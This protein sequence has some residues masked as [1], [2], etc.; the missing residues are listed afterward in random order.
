MNAINKLMHGKMHALGVPPI[1]E[2]L[3]MLVDYGAKLLV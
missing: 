3:Q 1:G 2:Y